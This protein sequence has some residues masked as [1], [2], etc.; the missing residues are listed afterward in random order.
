ML[1]VEYDEEEAP[2]AAKKKKRPKTI[3]VKITKEQQKEI[4]RLRKQGYGVYIAGD[5]K[6][7]KF[8][9]HPPS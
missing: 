3:A 9:F 7:M 4:V 8:P 1:G 2:M 6:I 5:G